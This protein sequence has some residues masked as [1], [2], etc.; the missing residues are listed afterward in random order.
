[1]KTGIAFLV[2]IG[3]IVLGMYAWSIQN[4]GISEEDLRSLGVVLLPEPVRIGEL[5]LVAHNGEVFDGKEMEGKWTFGFFGYTHCPDICPATMA[6]MGT[7][8]NRLIDNNETA[9][10]ENIQAMF[11]SVDARRDDYEKVRKFVH[12]VSDTFIGITGDEGKIKELASLSGIG[13]RKMGSNEVVDDYLIE[14]MGY[15]VIYDR[16]GDCFGYIKPPFQTDH[17]VRIFRGMADVG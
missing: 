8:V 9:V 7:A 3:V 14:H 16:N 10:L 5:D 13:Y 15:I 17:L 1:M 4:S 12:S 11:V 2:T 6:S